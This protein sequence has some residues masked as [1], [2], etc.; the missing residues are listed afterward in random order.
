MNRGSYCKIY[1]KCSIFCARLQSRQCEGHLCSLGAL[2]ADIWVGCGVSR[3]AMHLL[4][5]N[6]VLLDS[7]LSSN[8]PCTVREL[9]PRELLD[10]V[11]HSSQTGDVMCAVHSPGQRPASFNPDKLIGSRRGEGTLLAPLHPY[12][13][14]SGGG[15]P[16]KKHCC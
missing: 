1:H 2:P 15:L 3:K 16:P 8:A 13:R 4:T 12:P 7:T 10:R 11:N 9:Q 5:F 6:H 14:R